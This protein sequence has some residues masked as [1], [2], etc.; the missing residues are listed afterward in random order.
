MR[1][2]GSAHRRPAMAFGDLPNKLEAAAV[3]LF[4]ANSVSALTGFA[5]QSSEAHSRPAL[6]C[7]AE[8][9]EE[10]PQGSGNFNLDLTLQV[11]SQADDTPIATHRDY[12]GQVVDIFTDS[13]VA[14]GLSGTSTNFFAMGVFN[15]RFRSEV[16]DRAFIS[17]LTITVYCCASDL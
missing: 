16:Q 14:A 7:K 10:F 15:P 6:I 11:Q 4:A 1:G 8:Q 5:G 17:E 9:G 2:A 12:F 13:T 3:A